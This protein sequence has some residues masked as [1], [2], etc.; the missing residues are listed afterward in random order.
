MWSGLIWLK[1]QEQWWVV[2]NAVVY[3]LVARISY[4]DKVFSGSIKCGEFVD[5]QLLKAPS[6]EC[7]CN[8]R[9]LLFGHCSVFHHISVS[10]LRKKNL[11]YLHRSLF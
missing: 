9:L 5:F 1:R 6:M 3:A 11:S 8:G 2:T 10:F 7:V 4:N